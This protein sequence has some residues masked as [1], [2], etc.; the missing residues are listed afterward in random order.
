MRQTGDRA[1]LLFVLLMASCSGE[2]HRNTHGP[3]SMLDGNEPKETVVARVSEVASSRAPVIQ[4]A[5]GFTGLAV[6]P[7]ARLSIRSPKTGLLTSGWRVDVTSDQGS[8]SIVLVD[9]AKAASTF[10]G[11]GIF[12][13][14]SEA[15]LAN[16][17]RM[18]LDSLGAGESEL[19]LP[20][21]G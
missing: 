12:R 17:Y 14:W 15:R 3:S 20:Q 13:N 19:K 7:A 4:N 9:G 16:A 5:L 8:G 11:E 21:L 2:R 18:L 10:V 6:A 1:L